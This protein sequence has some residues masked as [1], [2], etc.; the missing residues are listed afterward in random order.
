MQRK[1]GIY[2]QT[3][4]FHSHGYYKNLKLEFLKLEGS[5]EQQPFTN[6]NFD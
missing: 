3:F 2:T 6:D 1:Y 5:S 4:I